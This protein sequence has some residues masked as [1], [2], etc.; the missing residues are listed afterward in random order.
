MTRTNLQFAI[1]ILQ[2]AIFATQYSASSLLHAAEQPAIS[3]PVSPQESLKHI[4]VSND[5]AV[6]LAASE[7]NVVSPVAVRFDENGRMWVVEMRDYPDTSVTGERARSVLKVLDDRNGDGF[8]ETAAVVSDDLRYATGVQ[9]WKGGVFVTMA[10]QVA[11]LKDTTGDDKADV[12]EPWYT[13]FSETNQQLRANHPRLALDN[14]IYI[15]NGLRGG[16]IIDAKQPGAKPVSI[17]G[18]DFRFD[19][20][21]RRFEP[22]SGVGQ[23][24]L[25]FDD[26]N[27]RFVC[28]NR[29]PTMHV[30]MEDSDLKKNPLVSV[31]AVSIDV[32]KAGADSRLFPVGKSWTT[33]NLHA[34]QFTAACGLEIFRGDGLPP[35]FRENIFVC[36]P[37]AH[38][39]HREVMK[40]KGVTFTS[41]PAEEGV[42][43]LASP[44]EWFSPVNLETGPDGALYVVDMYRAVIEH[45]EWM[46][47]EL[48]KRP[49]LLEGIDRGRIYRVVSKEFRRPAP[50]RLSALSNDKLVTTLAH[51]NAWWRE[52]AARLLLERQDKT[53]GPQLI[54]FATK[55]DAPHA[56]IR[57][58]WLLQAFE[59]LSDDLLLHLL[60]DHNPR[61]VEQAIIV[62]ASRL[63]KSSE[64][65]SRIAQFTQNADARVRFQALLAATPVPSWPK[66]PADQWELNAMLIA[67]GERGGTA[68]AN[69]LRNPAALQSNV[70]DPKRFVA[71]LARLAAASPDTSQRAI[72][73][74]A[75]RKSDTYRLVGLTSLLAETAR[76]GESLDDFLSQ[77]SENS[78]QALALSFE[79]AHAVSRDVKQSEVDRCDAIA[80]AALTNN[81]AESLGP[82]A[83]SD[84]SQVVR[85]AAIAALAKLPDVKAWPP[86]LDG[87][88]G[89]T[90]TMQRAILDGLT[91]KP[92]RVALLLDAIESGAVKP[93]ELDV[94]RAK[95]LLDHADATIK[96][97]VEKLLASA[98]PADRAKVLGEY[99]GVLDLESDPAR[100]QAIFQKNCATCHR[101]NNVGTD[102][103]PDISDSRERL[104]EQLLADIIQPNRAID[105]NYFSYTLVTTEG[106]THTGILT[107]ETSTSVTLKQAEGKTITLPRDQIDD[108]RSDGVSLMPDGL[109]KNI[110]PQEMADL[111]AFIK[112]WRYLTELP[113]K[114]R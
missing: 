31:T 34:G 7:P 53:V 95:Q 2:F 9:P 114:V 85:M 94:N 3:S 24:G 15:A 32:A 72:A 8:Y 101:I 69:I 67:A 111:I 96:Q 50:P 12:V 71:E 65:K 40:P 14:H 78:R 76:R 5:L 68:L 37:T 28:S 23:F 60:Y 62:A 25:T 105:S 11:Y 88:S 106:L 100:G 86:L 35:G 102:V 18:M 17:S 89:E 61:V 104:P 112:K 79:Q 83:V 43:F 93:T 6:E 47:T 109:E 46:P 66:F 77:L 63:D 33:S 13:G 87:F 59:L 41:S 27:N 49:D 16:E 73:I 10:G 103:A 22:V 80:L 108:L 51:P 84:E 52:T 98:V 75:L 99:H 21:T 30:V 110:S 70:P 4:V 91:A 57:A 81:A 29:N 56:R 1:C 45:P 58:L 36:D 107:A 44:D 55:H 82:L 39:V 74:D 113:N 97:R 38:L 54:Q 19:P 92:D 90:P 48:R 42:E 64:L 20:L 26:Y